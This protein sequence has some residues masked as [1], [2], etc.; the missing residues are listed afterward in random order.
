MIT[1]KNSM[2]TLK[3]LKIKKRLIRTV[4]KFVV[5]DSDKEK[6]DIIPVG[7]SLKRSDFGNLAFQ[8]T[9]QMIIL[10]NCKK[11]TIP[12]PKKHKGKCGKILN[13]YNIYL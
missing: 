4:V 5:W 2:T 13:N 3:T 7:S 6:L 12:V 11:I 8:S 10:P 1:L 9:E